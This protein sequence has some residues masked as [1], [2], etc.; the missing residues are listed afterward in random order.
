M[1]DRLGEMRGGGGGVMWP[2]RV[3]GTAE[4]PRLP[5]TVTGIEGV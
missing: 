2:V 3:S 4:G 1:P 5:V